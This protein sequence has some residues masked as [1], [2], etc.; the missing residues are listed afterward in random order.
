M[1]I[2]LMCAAAYLMNSIMFAL[3]ENVAQSVIAMMIVMIA[4]LTPWILV[5]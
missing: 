2:A 3:K 4:I 5:I 1:A